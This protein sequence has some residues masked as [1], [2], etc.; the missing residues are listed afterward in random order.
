[1]SKRSTRVGEVVWV[2]A[3][4][5]ALAA[6]SAAVGGIGTTIQDFFI[7]G[8]Q[9]MSLAV[10]LS[11]AQGCANCH[12][13][14]DAAAEPYTPWNHSMMAQAA[15]DP[16]FHACLAIANQDAAFSG[17]LCLRC[18]VPQGWIA[19]RS[20]DTTGG[21]LID[22]DM[23]GVSCSACHRMV[24]PVY[25]PGES[26]AVDQGILNSLAFPPQTPH[27]ASFVFDPQD[28]RRGPY[29][30]DITPHQWQ[31]SPFHRTAQM[32]ATCHDVSNPIYSRQVDGTYSLNA[33]DTPHETGNKYDQFPIERT[34]S[35]WSQSAFA[36]GPVEMGGRFGGN[37]T[38]VSSCQDCHMPKTSGTGC[39]PNQ[40]PTYRTDIGMHQFHGGN[41]WVLRAVDALY[42]SSQT[43]LNPDDID[44][45]IER[46][47]EMLRRAS[48]LSAYLDGP[49]LVVTVVNQT[50]HKLPTGYPEGR[51]MWLN[52]KFF[53]AGGGLLVE[54]GHYDAVTADLSAG[55]TKVYEAKLGLSPAIAAV[56]GEPAGESFHFAANNV[57]IKD[58]R[59][60]PR[61]FTNAG[62]ASVQAGHVGYA[63][64]DGHYWDQTRFLAPPG[65]VRAEARVFF[66]TTSKDYIEF[67]RD[68]NTTNTA[69]QVAYDQWVLHGKSAP[70]EMDFVNVD[71]NLCDPDFNADGNADQD[72]VLCMINTVAGNPGCST[73]DPDFNRD[74]N[75]DQ[76]DVVAIIN[77]V[78]GGGCP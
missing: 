29:A 62:F 53:D 26:P 9:P 6:V 58:N 70:V 65:T 13:F 8:S 31:Q 72:D 52:V 61:G 73:Q 69:G 56:L 77:A 76:D 16:I 17:D 12:A 28:R 27:N 25:R 15:R 48:D 18:H 45:S 41:T 3:L 2:S 24:D 60:P 66:Q 43:W 5:A 57:W 32:C 11:S 37:I 35:E 78:A 39:D 33:L 59:V 34:Y 63:Y 7:P 64:A 68:E 55:D 30:L 38:A 44:T 4:G 71:F 1:L 40:G 47:R 22:T 75:V 19:G 23:Q 14:Y 49:E 46:A 74:G 20:E 21:A 10:P 51:R 67:L 54:H 50:G 36:L 42:D